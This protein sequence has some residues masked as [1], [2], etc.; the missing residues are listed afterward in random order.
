MKNLN[1]YKNYILIVFISLVSFSYA[2]DSS[3]IIILSKD[4]GM[5]V[6]SEEKKNMQFLPDLMKI[7]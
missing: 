7:L 3:K 2:Q 5:I 6:D 4:I 1:V